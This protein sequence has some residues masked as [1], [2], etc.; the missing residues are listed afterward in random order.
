MSASSPSYEDDG[1]KVSLCVPMQQMKKD[2]SSRMLETEDLRGAF[3]E[4]KELKESISKKLEM[5]A[6]DLSLFKLV[7]VGPNELI[8]TTQDR[9]AIS[10]RHR[11][12]NQALTAEKLENVLQENERLKATVASLSK[13][14]VMLRRAL[15][16]QAQERE[17]SVT[18]HRKNEV[19]DI[20]EST[21]S[22]LTGLEMELNQLEKVLSIDTTSLLPAKEEKDD[23]TSPFS[24]NSHRK[25]V[26]DRAD[27]LEVEDF[28]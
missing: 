13:S 17:V 25:G 21:E 3:K 14:I 9:F 20:S 15:V 23:N 2:F 10:S 24:R 16:A 5:D 18:K 7:S 11:S 19:I 8:S 22:V 27:E 4:A 12:T 1:L 26:T 6:E 28:V